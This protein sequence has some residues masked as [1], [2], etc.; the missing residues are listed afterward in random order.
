M[1][2]TWDASTGLL[3][4]QNP[5]ENKWS[6]RL[7]FKF[8]AK[9]PSAS[10]RAGVVEWCDTGIVFDSDFWFNRLVLQ[11]F[12]SNPLSAIAAALCCKSIAA[13]LETILRTDKLNLNFSIQEA[14]QR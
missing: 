8:G 6:M 14:K 13:V 7:D 4:D 10:R 3:N 5:I 9:Y 1:P 11:E 12:N 2:E